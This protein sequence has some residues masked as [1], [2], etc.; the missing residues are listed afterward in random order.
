[1][2]QFVVEAIGLS[3]FGGLLGVL[4]G[5][6]LGIGISETI[7]HFAE[8]PFPS[9]VSYSSVV[10]SLGISVSIGLFFGIYPAARAASLDP[11]DALSF[12]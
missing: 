3:V 12:E 10:L 9:I 7:E 8:Q 6:G 2:L 4:V 1:M 5:I 11:V